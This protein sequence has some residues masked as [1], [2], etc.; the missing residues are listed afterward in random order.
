MGEMEKPVLVHQ[1][2][3]AKILGVSNGQ[4]FRKLMAQ[5]NVEPYQELGRITLYRKADIEALADLRKQD[6]ARQA[7]TIQV[8]KAFI[9]SLEARIEVLENAL[10]DIPR[11]VAKL[12]FEGSL[13]QGQEA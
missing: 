11:P 13:G 6:E 3:A 9:L 8:D 4:F 2:D 12:P 10:R 5:H 1:S 7:Q